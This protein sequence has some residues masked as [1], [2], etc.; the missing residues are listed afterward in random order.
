M[1]ASFLETALF[2]PA[3]LHIDPFNRF[4]C[5]FP[6]F[7]DGHPAGSLYLLTEDGFHF[8]VLD[9]HLTAVDIHDLI[10]QIFPVFHFQKVV[11]INNFT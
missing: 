2:Y 6:A 10:Q 8:A 7:L 1:L 4:K 9:E 3:I 5:Y 11:I